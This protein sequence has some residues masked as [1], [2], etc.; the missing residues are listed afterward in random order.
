MFVHP[1]LLQGEQYAVQK[2][3]AHY[4]SDL[5]AI[6]LHYSQLDSTFTDSWPP[7][8][9]YGQWML[10]CKDTQTSGGCGVSMDRGGRPQTAGDMDGGMGFG[11]AEQII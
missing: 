10:L 9:T 8:L 11:C 6:F 1:F 7:S 4:T 5:R 2:V 3:L